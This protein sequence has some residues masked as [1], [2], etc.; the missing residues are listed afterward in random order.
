MVIITFIYLTGI[1]VESLNLVASPKK[2]DG[3]Y[4][5]KFSGEL[6]R[7]SIKILMKNRKTVAYITGDCY[8]YFVLKRNLN[9]KLINILYLQRICCNSRLQDCGNCL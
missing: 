1:H 9:L 3:G 2:P 4:T 7:V 5:V 6:D 8:I